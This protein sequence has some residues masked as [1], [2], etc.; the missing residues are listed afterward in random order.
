MSIVEGMVTMRLAVVSYPSISQEDHNWMQ[1]I[2]AQHDAYYQLIAPH[3][4]FVFPCSMGEIALTEHIRRQS[5]GMKQIRF[6]IR[7]AVVIKDTTEEMTHVFLTPDEGFSDIV[8]LHDRL[9]TGI[10]ASE[11][12]LDIPFIP[13]IGI[14][15]ASDPLESKRLA[16]SLNKEVFSVDG[17]I[18][19]LDVV[20]VDIDR[21]EV[22]TIEQVKLT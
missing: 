7:C 1:A 15:N 21:R 14:G 16:D 17:T 6:V 4:T 9:Y 5:T 13:H 12:R 3:F 18:D 20:S 2:R 11:L 8:K 19:T 22:R 10:L